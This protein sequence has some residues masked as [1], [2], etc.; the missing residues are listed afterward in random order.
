MVKLED[1]MNNK[2]LETLQ[3]IFEVCSLVHFCEKDQYFALHF[4]PLTPEPKVYWKWKIFKM[5]KQCLVSDNRFPVI[6]V[7]LGS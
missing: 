6:I 2:N 1:Q 4:F 7:S 3:K 5:Q